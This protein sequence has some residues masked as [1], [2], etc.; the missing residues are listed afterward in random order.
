MGRGGTPLLG[1][2]V[3]VMVGSCVGVIVCVAV[4][5]GGV[6]C[7]GGS[8][9]AKL[10]DDVGVS[11]EANRVISAIT[12]W[13]ADVYSAPISSIVGVLVSLLVH[14]PRLKE[15]SVMKD[16]RINRYLEK[17]LIFEVRFTDLPPSGCVFGHSKWCWK[18]FSR[19][20]A[21]Y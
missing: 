13:A 14:A 20:V 8:S 1:V 5:V 17:E 7:M 2:V 16:N 21:V 9:V 3:S 4:S 19:L 10:A 11:D 6:S 15:T 12:V 18:I